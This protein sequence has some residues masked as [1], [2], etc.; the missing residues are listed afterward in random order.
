MLVDVGRG[1]L[2]RIA[3]D[4]ADHD[5]GVRGLVFVEQADGVDEIGPMIRIAADADAGRL[6][7]ARR[8]S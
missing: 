1:G 4:F 3:P 7:D 2:L 6:A 8:V 5:D